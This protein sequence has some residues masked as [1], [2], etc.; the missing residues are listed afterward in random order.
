MA[1]RSE[2]SCKIPDC[3]HGETAKRAIQVA[4]DD[5]GEGCF[6]VAEKISS[7]GSNDVLL[8]LPICVFS[9]H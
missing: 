3:E 4:D 9:E 7:N 1:Y 8:V 2:S 6:I 5:C